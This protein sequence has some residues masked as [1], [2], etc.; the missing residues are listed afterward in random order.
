[1]PAVRNFTWAPPSET[2]AHDHVRIQHLGGEFRGVPPLGFRVE[3]RGQVL[4]D[5]Q[6]EQRIYHVLA[7]RIGDL[8]YGLTRHV[9]AF[10]VRHRSDQPSVLHVHHVRL[11]AQVLGVEAPAAILVVLIPVVRTDKPFAVVLDRAALVGTHSRQQP[12]AVAGLDQEVRRAANL[13][14]R[15]QRG[16]R[17]L[18]HRYRSSCS[19]PEQSGCP[20]NPAP[21]WS[22][23]CLSPIPP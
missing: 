3:L 7:L 9:G 10:R 18:R 20:R 5:H 16:K 1:M 23:E 14:A 19:S 12:V 15:G 22:D 17:Q 4:L 8:L 11:H 21:P 13:N 6:V 2:P